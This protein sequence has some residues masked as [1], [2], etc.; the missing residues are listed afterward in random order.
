MK[1]LCEILF[2]Q[3][4]PKTARVPGGLSGQSCPITQSTG[5]GADSQRRG[6]PGREDSS[7]PPASK[8]QCL[9]TRSTRN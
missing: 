9:S 1:V 4:V 8:S 5:T 7:L 3:N 2:H 6:P